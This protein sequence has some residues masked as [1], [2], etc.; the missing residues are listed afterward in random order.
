MEVTIGDPK[1]ALLGLA[2]KYYADMIVIGSHGRTG[3]RKFLL[4]NVAQAISHEAPCAVAVVRGIVE[5]DE[6]WRDTGAYDK[7]EPIS[8]EA[9]VSGGLR[10]RDYHD[11]KPHILP[12]GM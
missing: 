10:S 6:S 2:N 11:D 9:L 7:L 4:G 3:L 12:T 8:I 5:D 1:D